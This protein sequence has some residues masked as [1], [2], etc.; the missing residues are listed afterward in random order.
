MRILLNAAIAAVIMPWVRVAVADDR[1]VSCLDRTRLFPDI[2][3]SVK[4]DA[5]TQSSDASNNRQPHDGKIYGKALVF[6]AFIRK[7]Q[8]ATGRIVNL[9][10]G[11]SFHDVHVQTLYLT[12]SSVRHTDVRVEGRTPLEDSDESLTAFYVQESTADAYFET[13]DDEL[14]IPYVEG[15]AIYFNGGLPHQSIVKSGAV[16]LVGP[17]LL[18][19]LES[20]GGGG[21]Y[22]GMDYDDARKCEQYCDSNCSDCGDLPPCPVGENCIYVAEPECVEPPSLSPSES[23]AVSSS[24]SS[25]GPKA[26]KVSSS[27]QV[28][29]M[30][31]SGSGS[32]LPLTSLVGICL[33]SIVALGTFTF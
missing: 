26:G 9:P 6:P 33:V 19:T 3:Y 10:D 21:G 27:L 17:F 7:M 18:S 2:D 28:Q 24:K 32:S 22:C 16:K 1:H 5:A 25:K 29:Q 20:V 31:S 30:K 14:C 8:Q 13:D 15:S 23:P 4:V 11:Y 12:E